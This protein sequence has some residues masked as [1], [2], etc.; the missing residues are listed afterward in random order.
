MKAIRK[1]SRGTK[2]INLTSEINFLERGWK[3]GR[4]NYPKISAL[5]LPLGSGAVESLIRQVVNLRLKGNSKLWLK[6]NAEVILHARCQWIAG[7]WEHFCETVLTSR[8][9]PVS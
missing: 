3:K 9:L 6:R 7:S 2:R 1:N 4:L 5:N 8:I